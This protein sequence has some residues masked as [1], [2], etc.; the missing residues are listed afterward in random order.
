MAVGPVLVS[1]YD[2]CDIFNDMKVTKVTRSRTERLETVK[3]EKK[4][5]KL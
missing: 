2:R 3:T 4:K 5:K 1:G